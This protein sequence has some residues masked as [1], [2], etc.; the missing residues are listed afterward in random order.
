MILTFR[1]ICRFLRMSVLII[2]QVKTMS[3]STGICVTL[4]TWMEILA[5][6]LSAL[7]SAML[8]TMWLTLKSQVSSVTVQ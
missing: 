5:A 3:H 7:E 8:V 1:S 2:G 6:A 4:A